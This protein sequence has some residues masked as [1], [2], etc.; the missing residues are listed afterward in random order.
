MPLAVHSVPF[1][2]GL[3][4]SGAARGNRLAMFVLRYTQV[5]YCIVP[6][7]IKLGLFD[8]NGVLDIAIEALKEDTSMRCLRSHVLGAHFNFQGVITAWEI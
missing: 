6:P 3:V 8:D 5:A 7:N 2:F 4:T 1:L